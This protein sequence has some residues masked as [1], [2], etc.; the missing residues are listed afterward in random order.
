M[1]GIFAPHSVPCQE[2]RTAQ[3]HTSPATSGDESRGC[4]AE[5]K[6]P[7]QKALG[8]LRRVKKYEILKAFAIFL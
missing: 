5:A 4:S 6:V 8:C 2:A 3:K 1:S 7:T